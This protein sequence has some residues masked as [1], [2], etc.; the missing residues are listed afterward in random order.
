MGVP[1]YRNLRNPVG[2]T[3]SSPRSQY[4]LRAFRLHPSRRKMRIFR[5]VSIEDAFPKTSDLFSDGGLVS[6]G[7]GS[8]VWPE[9]TLPYLRPFFSDFFQK[10][11]MKL[12]GLSVG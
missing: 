4:S 2:L 1:G 6:T 9:F 8:S 3:A 12:M 7:I 10:T 11:P 5:P